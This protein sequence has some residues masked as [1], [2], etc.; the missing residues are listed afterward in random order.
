MIF[1]IVP[2]LPSNVSVPVYVIVCR[3]AAVSA[4]IE[5]V[6]PH[7]LTVYVTLL[8]TRTAELTHEPV[9]SNSFTVHVV[10]R[11]EPRLSSNCIPA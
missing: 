3:V 2:L 8:P 11:G 6:P 1:C 4:S 10:P 9:I 7:P 5:V